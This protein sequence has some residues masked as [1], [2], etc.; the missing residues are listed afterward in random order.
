[1][2]WFNFFFDH[3]NQKLQNQQL[4]FRVKEAQEAAY[5]AGV[6]LSQLAASHPELSPSL[7][8]LQMLNAQV[9]QVLA[10]VHSFLGG[11]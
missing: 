8:H 9:G 2:G 3:P 10:Q 7:S 5:Q 4:S 1:M 11:K 6:L